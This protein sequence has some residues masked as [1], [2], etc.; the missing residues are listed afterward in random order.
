MYAVL[1]LT[2]KPS[3]T[4][5]EPP[6]GKA[7]AIIRDDPYTH[8][9]VVTDGYL[10]LGATPVLPEYVAQI[11]TARLTGETD[12]DPL[13]DFTVEVEQDGDDFRIT[14]SLT[15]EQTLE[16]PSSGFWDMQQVDAGTIL[17]GKIKVLDDVSR[18]A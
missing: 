18:G 6:T 3:V 12:D 4:V 5:T 15:A 7:S 13:A 2:W 17:A 1:D 14:M 9:F 11:R 16:L 10:D 8:V